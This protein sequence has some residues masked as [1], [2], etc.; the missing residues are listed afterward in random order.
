VDR[1]IS[2][3]IRARL[4][5][6]IDG[7]FD[8]ES[9][10]VVYTHNA[11]TKGDTDQAGALGLSVWSFGLPFAEIL[12]DGDVLR[13]YYAGTEAAMDIHWSRLRVN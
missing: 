10:V 1:F 4:A 5:P 6:S 3:S 2:Q 8:P 7:D 13:L 9:E 11:P 12:P